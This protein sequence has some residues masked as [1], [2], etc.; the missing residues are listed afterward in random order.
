MQQVGV[1][2]ETYG[3]APT[4]LRQLAR[5]FLVAFAVAVVT[6][7]LSGSAGRVGFGLLGASALLVGLTLAVDLN[8]SANHVAAAARRHPVLGIA[9][10]VFFTK[11][12]FVRL[13]GLV[14][15][16]VGIVF[17]LTAAF[18]RSLHG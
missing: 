11:Q 18:A 10:P 6:M 1:W 5:L 8:G 14:F 17:V 12:P 13:F 2:R 16:V 4:P 7:F 15:A 9:A 3:T